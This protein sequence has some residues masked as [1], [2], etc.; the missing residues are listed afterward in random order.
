MME[1]FAKALAIVLILGLVP[2]GPDSFFNG[3]RQT[4]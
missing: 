4:R 1:H 2:V 3:N